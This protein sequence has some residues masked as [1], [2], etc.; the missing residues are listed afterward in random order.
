MPVPVPVD[1]TNRVTEVV[2]VVEV[3]VVVSSSGISVMVSPPSV[4][5]NGLSVALG[6]AFMLEPLSAG[7]FVGPV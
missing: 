3:V 5:V 4:L 2:L 6:E 7:L 1:V